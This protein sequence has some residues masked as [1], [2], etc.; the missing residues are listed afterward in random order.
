M[1]CLKSVKG[2]LLEVLSEVLNLVQIYWFFHV[3]KNDEVFF[4]TG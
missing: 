4:L 2:I 3:R 1:E